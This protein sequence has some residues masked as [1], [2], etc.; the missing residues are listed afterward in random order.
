MRFGGLRENR[1]KSS[2][3]VRN[4]PRTQKVLFVQERVVNG[5]G[6]DERLPAAVAGRQ[7]RRP[8]SSICRKPAGSRQRLARSGAVKRTHAHNF[9]IIWGIIVGF[10]R[11]RPGTGPGAD[12]G[13]SSA[14]N[15]V[16]MTLTAR[17]TA[18]VLLAAVG[19]GYMRHPARG[20]TYRPGRV[21]TSVCDVCK[22]LSQPTDACDRSALSGIAGHCSGH[23]LRTRFRPRGRR[24][25]CSRGVPL[26]SGTSG[27]PRRRCPLWSAGQAVDRGVSLG[28]LRSAG[29]DALFGH[30]PVS[31][32]GSLLPPPAESPVIW[33][34]GAPCCRFT[35]FR[36]LMTPCKEGKDRRAL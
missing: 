22:Y 6:V 10:T 29:S 7:R 5:E 33:H 15:M 16:C 18:T 28:Y 32:G 17:L 8:H 36:R 13:Q 12:A 31:A 14:Y 25:H 2:A 20:G 27:A 19:A 9:G 24:R 35:E 23:P 34:G 4:A 26:S 3:A 11:E 30:A 21:G 1:A